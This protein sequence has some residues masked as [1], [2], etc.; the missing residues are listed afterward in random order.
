MAVP[1]A[2]GTVPAIVKADAYV[3]RGSKGP[4]GWRTRWEKIQYVQAVLV[5]KIFRGLPPPNFNA[6]RLTEEV[7]ERLKE[8][9]DY[10]ATG[11][12]RILTTNAAARRLRSGTFGP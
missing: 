6:T 10:R 4:A 7:N 2:P 3:I 12:L 11:S 5:L 1:P 8:D 9:P